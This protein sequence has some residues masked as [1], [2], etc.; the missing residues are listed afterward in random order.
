MAEKVEVDGGGPEFNGAILKNAATETTLER[1][2]NAM[3]SKQKGL[4]DKILGVA[5]KVIEE[6][7]K[8]NKDSTSAFE[9][10]NQ[11]L[12]TGT[13]VG[14][15]MIETFS[16]IVGTGIGTTFS[17]LS[18]AGTSFLE[19]VK[20]GYSAFQE[21]SKVGASFNNDLF[22]LRIAAAEAQMPLDEFTKLM[23]QNS[24]TFAKFGMSVTDGAFAFT[25]MS[26]RIK[27]EFG[28]KLVGLGFSLSDI[29]DGLATYLDIQ[30]K[31]GRVDKVNTKDLVEGTKNYLLELDKVTKLTGMSRKAQEDLARK[32]SVDPIIRTM[33]E[34]IEGNVE[35]TA[36]AQA[37][38][39]ILQQLGGDQ[40]VQYAK[41]LAAM[42]PGPQAAMLANQL[43]MGMEDF[44]KIF[45]GQ[46]DPAELLSILKDRRE[47][48]K[49]L[50]DETREQ[51]AAIAMSNE[52]FAKFLEMTKNAEGLGDYN[53]IKN[54]QDAREKVT[55]GLGVLGNTF[56]RI[57]Y[58]TLSK[59]MTSTVFQDFVASLEKLADKFIENSGKIVRFFENMFTAV[60]LAMTNFI[61]NIDKEG[62]GNAM[63][64]FFK[65]MF[66]Y[67]GKV[68]G[69]VLSE[70][71]SSLFGPSKEQLQQQEAFKNATP[72]QQ[73]EMKKQN[74]NI[75]NPNATG[76]LG[77]M[78]DGLKSLTNLIPSLTELAGFFGVTGIGAVV[79]GTGMSYGIGLVAKGL[80]SLV[81]PAWE[82][83]VPVGAL[84]AALWGLSKATE[85][86]GTVLEKLTTF[87]TTIKDASFEDI[88]KMA[89][90]LFSFG[91]SVGQ[92]G[93]GGILNLIGGGGVD[94]FFETLKKVK[95]IDVDRLSQV[96]PAVKALS[97][98]YAVF[99]KIS[100]VEGFS[101]SIMESIASS[102]TK[103][104]KLDNRTITSLGPVSDFFN[105]LKGLDVDP[106]K[107][108]SVV[109]AVGVL[110]TTMDQ[111]FT[112]DT[113]KVDEFTKSI[114]NLVESL[115]KLEDQMKKTPTTTLAT[116]NVNSRGP[117]DMS[118]SG[119]SPEDLQKQLNMQVAE[120]IQHIVEM[121]EISKSTSDSISDRRNA[122]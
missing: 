107:I 27:K 90:A 17:L 10:F 11:T 91:A 71:V 103:L 12:N 55:E 63:L 8:A 6:N 122:I 51:Q 102:M 24:T 114:N 73:A 41:E 94:N 4:K 48:T 47:A 58:G 121:K 115:G 43:Q 9:S 23:Q 83:T 5:N 13:K 25:G 80:Q 72:E 64:D 65:D 19:F 44:Q 26:S 96:G 56:N 1:L 30:S 85:A 110:R 86:T 66:K 111:N 97:D 101:D 18:T 59:I 100:L 60:D 116:T 54:E 35:A 53:A 33:M 70:T 21:T 28:D 3:E 39:A 16:S 79:A 22:A 40:A 120:L 38:L 57:Y 61:N 84:A 2:A 52:G 75:D 117:S 67:L 106:A 69:P 95:E 76:F 109:S 99:S 113:S 34:G 46:M 119:S 32:V 42:R 31:I 92:I 14:S 118:I 36:K 88:G 37:N 87:F 93:T 82:L 104:D 98:G 112:S 78:V 62:I 105:S 15:K 49:A 81:A 7:V 50:D 108:E 77:Q 89:T 29:N 68:I 74:P 45:R 20:N